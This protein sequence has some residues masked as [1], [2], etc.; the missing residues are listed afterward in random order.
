MLIREP[1]QRVSLVLPYYSR[2]KE[3]DICAKRLQKLYWKYRDVMQLVISEDPKNYRDKEMHYGMVDILSKYRFCKFEICN[4]DRE[5][6][7]PSIRYNYGVQHA[8]GDVLILS[9]PEIYHTED[10][11]SYLKG[12]DLKNSYYVFDCAAVQYVS[13]N[14]N[15]INV[16]FIRWYQHHEYCDRGLNFLSVISKENYERIG[17]FDEEYAKGLGY[18][19]N[20]FL[21]RVKAAKIRTI[22]VPIICYHI[23]HDRRYDISSHEMDRQRELNLNRWK[24]QI[25]SGRF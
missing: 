17:G 19:D 5:S 6:Y 4:D 15:G 2:N 9:C 10:I 16:R 25:E 7:S 18:E 23:E 1:S 8:W 21:A 22:N 13:D 24:M 3:F 12:K 14:T 20:N 11:I